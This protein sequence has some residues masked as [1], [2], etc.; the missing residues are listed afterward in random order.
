MLKKIII[1]QLFGMLIAQQLPYES[2]YYYD[3]N[4]IKPIENLFVDIPFNI[5]DEFIKKVEPINE[6]NKDVY[7]FEIKFEKEKKVQF[8]IETSNISDDMTIFFIN[9][10]TNGWVGPYDKYTTFDKETIIT[11]L[12]KGNSVIIEISLNKNTIFKNPIHSIIYPKKIIE[13]K[14]KIRKKQVLNRQGNNKILLAGYWPPSNEGIRPFSKNSMLNPNGWIGQNWEGSGYDILSYFPSF[15]E[16]DCESCGQGFGDLEVDYQDTSV[17]WWNIVDSINPIAI[18][19]FSRGYIDY[20]WELEWQY[21]NSITWVADF[22]NPYLPTPS[23]PDSTLPQNT[24]RYTTLPMEDIINQIELA[25]IGLTPYI[26]YTNGAGNYLSEYM[27]Y[28]GVWQKSKMDSINS[29]CIVAGHVHVGGLID[30]D[31]ARQAVEITVREVIKIVNEYQNLPGD[32]NHDGVI[33]ILDILKIID[34]LLWNANLTT[35]EIERADVNL[36]TKVDLF[37]LILISNIILEW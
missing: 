31:T 22:T 34:Y 8:K 23:P 7:L 6:N 17:D 36:D 37:D 32:I 29:P 4:M 30:W 12:L 5:P 19:T 10:E 24:P 14:R 18:I 15:S 25:D 13:K 35:N 27:G 9:S 1:F 26:D 21:Y 33:S 2:P 16:P 28:H 20:S 11:G 3:I